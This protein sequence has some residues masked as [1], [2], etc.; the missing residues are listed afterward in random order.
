MSSPPRG[1]PDWNLLGVPPLTMSTRSP[2][3]RPPE[4]DQLP[5]L[6][7]LAEE[8]G[9][10]AVAALAG[11]VLAAVADVVDVVALP[12][13]GL[14]V[15]ALVSTAVGWEEAT[16]V[17]AVPEAARRPVSP[18]MPVALRT[19]TASRARRAGWRRRVGVGVERGL[20]LIGGLLVGWAGSARWSDGRGQASE[21]PHR[22]PGSCPDPAPQ[23]VHRIV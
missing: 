12:V 2:D 10:E 7:V 6:E 11:V 23:P 9:V 14:A 17:L 1:L 8:L 15:T 16:V 21:D 22:G 20:V 4:P 19:P 13:L 3:R 5:E 18:R